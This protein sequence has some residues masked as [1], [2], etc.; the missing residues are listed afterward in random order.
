VPLVYVDTSERSGIPRSAA[1]GAMGHKTEALYR[2][3]RG[4]GHVLRSRRHARPIA[5]TLPSISSDSVEFWD[6]RLNTRPVGPGPGNAAADF[7]RDRR[8]VADVTLI[9]L[10]AQILFAQRLDHGR[11]RSGS[12]RR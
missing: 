4:R 9:Q 2:R 12:L 8:K 3:Y 1:M 10:H 5:G 6:S 7:I 11:T